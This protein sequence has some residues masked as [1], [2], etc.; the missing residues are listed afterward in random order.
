MQLDHDQLRSLLALLGESDI[1]ELCLE[2]D[3]FRLE[4]RRNLSA[5][6]PV[7]MVQAPVLASPPQAPVAAASPSVPPPAPPAVR[8]DLQ[9]ITAPM[10]GTFYRSPAPGEP[11]FVEIGSRISAG[12]PVCILE[13]M[14]LMNELESEISG[15]V[16][17]ILLESGTPVEFGQVL[18]RIKP[19]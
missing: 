8:S 5:A 6:A 1:Q 11:A 7:A 3:D 9:A 19:A 13:A 15:E 18:M 12:Q 17:E 14:K 16:V 10:V 2:G 4:V